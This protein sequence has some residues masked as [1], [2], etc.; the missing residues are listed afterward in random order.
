MMRWTIILV[1]LLLVTAGG[2]AIWFYSHQERL[3]YKLEESWERDLRLAL[4]THPEN[5]AILL[6]KD[7]TVLD[8][9]TAAECTRYYK[10]KGSIAWTCIVNKE[11][12]GHLSSY[13]YQREDAK[14]FDS[15]YRK[16][17][18]DA[19]NYAATSMKQQNIHGLGSCHAFW[20]FKKEFLQKHGI[21]WQSP[22]QLNPNISFD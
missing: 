16:Q 1:A 17:I 6:E 7:K 14:E 12:N 21:K 19:E 18:D 5:A 20:S 2:S 3:Q 10:I 11:T 8:S 9:N 13:M 4:E 15:K 22:A